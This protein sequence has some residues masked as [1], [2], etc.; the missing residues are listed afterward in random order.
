[1]PG[2]LSGVKVLELVKKGPGAFVTMMLADMGADVIKVEAPSP[3]GESGSGESPL[4]ADARAQAANIVNRGKRSLVL[5]LKAE[6]GREVLHA[7]ARKTDVVVEGFRPGVTARLSADYE[8]LRIGNRRLIYCSLSGYGQDGPYR[9]LPGHDIN[10]I[11]MA[12]ILNLIGEPGKP[13][14]VP[15][16]FIADLGGAALH[17]VAGI[18]LAL[19]ARERTGNGQL[20]DIAYLDAAV[21]LLAPTSIIR[22]HLAGGAPVKRGMGALGGRFPYYA[23]YETSD[24]K[25]I[26]IGCIEPWL[27]ANLCNAIERP[28]LIDAGLQPGDYTGKESERQSWCRKELERIFKTRSRDEWFELLARADVCTGKVYE[29]PELFDDPQLKHRRMATRMSHPEIGEVKQIGIA[30]KLSDTPGSIRGFAPWK[31]QH[32]QEIL[33]ELGNS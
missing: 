17:A 14:I 22:E 1:M 32:T 25:F 27:W 3:E 9:D 26:S 6:R 2:P 33:A 15:L 13:P 29:I 4:A 16:N 31:G 12:G 24:A 18:V 21:S 5:D 20:V 8:T 30:I 10:Y 19:F 7:L 11:A 28:D 23:V